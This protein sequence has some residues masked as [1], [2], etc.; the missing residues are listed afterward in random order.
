MIEVIEVIVP[1]GLPLSSNDRKIVTV[2]F[3]N[4]QSPRDWTL[5]ARG[6]HPSG[7]P[8][9]CLAQYHPEQS[10]MTASAT[11]GR[12]Q[13]HPYANNSNKLCLLDRR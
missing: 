3:S 12:I 2:Q 9:T 8:H 1:S 11:A 13:K 6:H 4:V 7:C 10:K 5:V